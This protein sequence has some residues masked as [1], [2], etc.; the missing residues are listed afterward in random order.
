MSLEEIYS[1]Q[2]SGNGSVISGIPHFGTPPVMERDPNFIQ[3]EQSVFQQLQ[4][5][6]EPHIQA[7]EVKIE[8]VG[9]V[10]FEDALRELVQMNK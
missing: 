7:S 10:S 9:V 6:I 5:V 4:S 1:K 8:E 3:L 2:V